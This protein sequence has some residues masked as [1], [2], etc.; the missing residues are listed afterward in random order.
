MFS[1]TCS[2]IRGF[3]ERY[4]YF[5]LIKVKWW[6]TFNEPWIVA[7]LGYGVASFAPGVYGPGTT[8][9]VVAHNLIKAH[10]EAW[11]CYDDDYRASQ[12]GMYG[13]DFW[14][15]SQISCVA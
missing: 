5:A 7:W 13:I 2:Y 10:A 9:Y 15:L 11:H 3:I 4:F 14:Y 6:I 12:N 1:F 8:V